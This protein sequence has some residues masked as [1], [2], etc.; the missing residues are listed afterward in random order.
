MPIASIQPN[1]AAALFD[2]RS[3]VCA[4][5]A[6]AGAANSGEN[7]PK[8]GQQAQFASPM[9]RGQQIV[10]AAAHF[11]IAGV[12]PSPFYRKGNGL[13]MN[14]DKEVSETNLTTDK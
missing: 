7:E 6:Q 2:F 8:P 5:A 3:F 12:F 11:E 4:A 13:W 10:S 14:A 9:P 1:A